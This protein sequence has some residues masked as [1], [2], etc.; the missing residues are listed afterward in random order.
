MIKPFKKKNTAKDRDLVSERLAQA[1]KRSKGKRECTVTWE[2]LYDLLMQQKG[3]C[4]LSGF[5]MTLET[6]RENVI[7]LDRIDS[8][9]GYI[10][11][12]VQWVCKYINIMKSDMP[13][14]EFFRAIKSI[15]EYQE[16]QNA[17]RIE[18]YLWDFI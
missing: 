12:N 1:R 8:T 11:G 5:Q 15:L 13:E 10:P 2:Y 3:I 6:C 9:K 7:S 17:T 16:K 4:A 14:P 18:H